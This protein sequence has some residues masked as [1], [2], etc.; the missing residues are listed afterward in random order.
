MASGEAA[1]QLHVLRFSVTYGLAALAN[2]AGQ[3]EIA[4]VGGLRGSDRCP[5]CG[6]GLAA[7]GS[8]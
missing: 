2:D 6:T 5:Q 7:T 3:A 8:V 4:V 1:T